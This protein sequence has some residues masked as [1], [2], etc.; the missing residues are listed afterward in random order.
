MSGCFEEVVI[1]DTSERFKYA[2]VTHGVKQRDFVNP[3][4][5]EDLK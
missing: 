5:N 2:Y 3:N 4:S 1:C